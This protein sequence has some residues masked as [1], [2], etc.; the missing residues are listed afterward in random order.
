MFLLPSAFQICCDMC[1]WQ[2]MLAL[3][4]AIMIVLT[5]C[6]TYAPSMMSRCARPSSLCAARAL[7]CSHF[8]QI[9]LDRRDSYIAVEGAPSDV[10]ASVPKISKV[11]PLYLKT[12]IVSNISLCSFRRIPSMLILLSPAFAGHVCSARSRPQVVD[13]PA[14]GFG[15]FF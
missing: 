15:F 10:E 5:H 13:L 3:C 14:P 11:S 12:H 1:F 9:R 4:R 2:L 6:T 8:A 7:P